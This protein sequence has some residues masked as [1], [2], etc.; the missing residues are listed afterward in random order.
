MS[1]SRRNSVAN[2]CNSGHAARQLSLPCL[3]S[4]VA[5]LLGGGQPLMVWFNVDDNLH[6]HPKARK[7]GLEAVGLWTVCGSFS[8]QYL[9]EGFVPGWKVEAYRNGLKLAQK[10]VD[11]GLWVYAEM[12]GEQGWRFHQ[13]DQ[14]NRTKAQVEA[15]KAANR[16]RQRKFREG[17]RNAVTNPVNNAPRN[18]V[19]NSVTEEPDNAV[20]NSGSN[21]VSNA[22]LAV[23]SR[24]NKK[25][26]R[27]GARTS[28]ATDEEFDQFWAKYPRREGKGYARTAWAKALKKTDA[29]TLIKE[30]GAYAARS[31]G[32]DP[33][34]IPLPAT[35]LN[36]ERW[37]DEQSTPLADWMS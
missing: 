18:A 36:G 35:W 3:W 20:T 29:A 31:I 5:N 33:K 16:E 4:S 1:I 13:W 8:S 28:A 17:Q 9:T 37:A 23:P 22:A 21:G 32:S 19:T 12:D 10:L 34:F 15:D 30:A 7:A 26:T 24:T 25:T 11:A 2:L 6:D 27:T 14:R